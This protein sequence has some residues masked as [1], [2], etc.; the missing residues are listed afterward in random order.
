MN[1]NTLWSRV[2]ESPNLPPS[3]SVEGTPSGGAPEGWDLAILIKHREGLPDGFQHS[4]VR[5]LSAGNRVQV[6][7]PK[8]ALP[9]PLVGLGEVDCE[10]SARQ[11]R[12]R[13]ANA[14]GSVTADDELRCLQ[15]G[16]AQCCN[17]PALHIQPW[18]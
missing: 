18:L 8:R 10:P 7:A 5:V 14:K 13:G 1:G 6:A 2:L 17:P 15:T 16:S 12:Q 11:T 3:M 9:L 4:L